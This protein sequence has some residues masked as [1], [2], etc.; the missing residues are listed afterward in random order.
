MEGYAKIHVDAGVRKGQG[1]SAAAVC[2]DRNGNFLGSSSLVIGGVDNPATLK[3]IACREA[4]ELTEDLRLH[5]VDI[6][7]NTKQVVLDISNSSRG[8]YIIISEIHLYSNLF[9]CKFI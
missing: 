8:S 2:R 1:G 7:S 4:L 6:A 5:C 3:S 9:Q